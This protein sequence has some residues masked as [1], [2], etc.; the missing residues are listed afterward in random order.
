MRMRAGAYVCVSACKPVS[1]FCQLVTRTCSLSMF[2]F[3]RGGQEAPRG[4]LANEDTRAAAVK[5]YRVLI[6]ILML[7]SLFFECELAV[8][9][10]SRT[11]MPIVE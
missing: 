4:V 3:I 5:T 6:L 9:N 2:P 10:A 1:S 11:D 7:S 8:C